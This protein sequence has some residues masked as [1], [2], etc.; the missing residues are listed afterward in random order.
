M[1]MNIQQMWILEYRGF[2]KGIQLDRLSKTN[3]NTVAIGGN[4]AYI[5]AARLPCAQ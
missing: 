4:A 5:R 2:V 1:F 3:N